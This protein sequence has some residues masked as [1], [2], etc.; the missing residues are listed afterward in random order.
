MLP[1]VGSEAV[2]AAV[3]PCVVGLPAAFDPSAFFHLV[4]QRIEGGQREFQC[5]VG[6]LADLLGN[7]EAIEG[8]L[9]QQRKD[10]QVTTAARDFG[11]NAFRNGLRNKQY[12]IPMFGV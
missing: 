6:S 12:R 7:F 4:K 2:V 10:G 11:T 9:S 1:A 3:A 8:L 5:A